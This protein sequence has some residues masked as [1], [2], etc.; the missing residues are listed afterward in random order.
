[1]FVNIFFFYLNSGPNKLPIKAQKLDD[2]LYP[3]ILNIK[4]KTKI[5]KNSKKYLTIF[6]VFYLKN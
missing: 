3:K 2:N 5:N 4:N 1:M 6:I